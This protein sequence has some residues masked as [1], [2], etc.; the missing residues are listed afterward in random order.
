MRLISRIKLPKYVADRFFEEVVT[1]SAKTKEKF[2]MNASQRENWKQ[3]KAKGFW[4]F[5]LVYWV[6]TAGGSMITGLTLYDYFFSRSG[7]NLEKVLTNSVCILIASFAAGTL[8]WFFN[9]RRYRKGAS[10][11]S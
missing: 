2:Y 8:L 4:H 5:V 7:F 1:G 11:D 6:L 3:V 9:K 10:A